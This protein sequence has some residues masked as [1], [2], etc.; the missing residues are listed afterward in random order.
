M[1]FTPFSILTLITDKENILKRWVWALWQCVLNCP[2]VINDDAINLPPQTPINEA[3][4]IMST[5]EELLKA[6]SQLSS[7]KASGSDSILAEM[8]KNGGPALV[9]RILRYVMYELGICKH[10]NECNY[11]YSWHQLSKEEKKIPSLFEQ[12]RFFFS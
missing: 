11:I 5:R 4:D 8:Y 6:I 1:H 3:L 10:Q 7:G 12:C 2:S 9:L